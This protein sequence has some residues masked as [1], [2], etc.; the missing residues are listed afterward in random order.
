[1]MVPGTLTRNDALDLQDFCV[2]LLERIFTEPK[3]LQLAAERRAQR[4]GKTYTLRRA[5]RRPRVFS[6]RHRI[7]AAAAG[8]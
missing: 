5:F 8:D 4:R 2:A 1:M 3:R 7:S 6:G